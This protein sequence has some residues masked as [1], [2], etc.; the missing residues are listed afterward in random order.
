MTESTRDAE[1]VAASYATRDVIYCRE[2]LAELYELQGKH[3]SKDPT[4]VRIDCQPAIDTIEKDG[5]A[6]KAKSIRLSHHKIRDLY[7]R[8]EIKPKW[9][10]GKEN[11]ADLLTKPL[12]KEMTNKYNQMMFGNV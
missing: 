2:F 11:P 9:I 1:H 3:A 8:N 10:S 5:F 7:E 6:D 12:S 4:I